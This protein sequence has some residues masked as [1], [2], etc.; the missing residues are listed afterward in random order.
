MQ[1]AVWVAGIYDNKISRI[2]VNSESVS[3]VVM[4]RH[5][6]G[7]GGLV[8]HNVTLYIANTNAHEIMCLNPNNGH[9]EAL[10]VA[11]ELVEI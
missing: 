9:A 5:S 10:N 7:P 1:R 6:D 2:V 8:F 4:G 11:E 3:R